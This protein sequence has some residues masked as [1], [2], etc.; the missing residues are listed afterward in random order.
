MTIAN[1]IRKALYSSPK[2]SNKELAKKFKVTSRYVQIIRREMGFPNADPRGRKKAGTISLTFEQFK[3]RFPT[4][5]K[6][7]PAP[8]DSVDAVLDERGKRYGSFAKQAAI[9]QE[10]K[11]AVIANMD[12]RL[13]VD[14]AAWCMAREALEMICVKMARILNG[15]LEYADNWLDIA[16]YAKLMADHLEGKSR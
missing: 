6:D 13:D 4:A 5:E 2:A 9:A 8:K 15:D 11:N 7:V 12:R 16:G 1:K 3:E 10:I 14:F